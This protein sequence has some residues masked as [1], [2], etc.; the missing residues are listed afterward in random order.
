[1]LV[2]VLRRPN[3]K[4]DHIRPHVLDLSFISAR[5]FGGELVVLS[6][7]LSMFMQVGVGVKVRKKDTLYWFIKGQLH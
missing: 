1:M 5:V 6:T 4:S 2:V 3:K 7:M